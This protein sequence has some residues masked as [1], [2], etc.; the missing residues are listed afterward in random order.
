[1]D[2]LLW[3]QIVMVLSLLVMV[4]VSFTIEKGYV[5]VYKIIG[6]ACCKRYGV[7]IDSC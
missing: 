2:L 1:M 7:M 6:C 4:S 3:D 5:V